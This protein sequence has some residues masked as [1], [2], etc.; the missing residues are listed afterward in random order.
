MSQS[1]KCTKAW[2]LEGGE[3]EPAN[4]V[5]WESDVGIHL[6]LTPDHELRLLPALGSRGKE[7]DVE[8]PCLVKALVCSDEEP[9]KLGAWVVVQLGESDMR[10]SGAGR[11][12][13][14]NQSMKFRMRNRSLLTSLA[15]SAWDCACEWS[16]KK[17]E[18]TWKTILAVTSLIV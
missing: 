1:A 6:S 18:L 4:G 9:R 14:C 15:S 5:V 13:F 3:F 2:F 10:Q 17:Q 7:G 12:L 8:P 16:I 11:R